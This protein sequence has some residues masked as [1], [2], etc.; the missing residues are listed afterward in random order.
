MRSPKQQP[1]R[2]SGFSLLEVMA[3]VA[4]LALMLALLTQ[5]SSST[6][7]A[8]TVTMKQIEATRSARAV[9]DTLSEDLAALVTSNDAASLF[10]KTD[11]ADSRLVFVTLR[12]GPQGSNARFIAVD[13]AL[14][15]GTVTRTVSPLA[16]NAVDFATAAFATNTLADT[17][18]LAEGIVRFEAVLNLDNGDTRTLADPGSWKAAEWNGTALPADFYAIHLSRDE[19][20]SV[21]PKVAGLTVAIAALDMGSY[22]L[23]NTDQIAAK[24]PPA[25]ANQTP[26]DTWKIAMTPGS[27]TGI[28][29]VAV[30][31]LRI[32]QRTYPL[33]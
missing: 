6:M 1:R 5:L 27:M 33:P 15:N 3:A 11:G 17:S 29:E 9:L 28:P 12:R 19:P 4:V 16:W 18:V 31:A 7:R 23:P 30:A 8:T 22:R 26:L 25:V 2:R 21:Q 20:D 24:L 32:L 13:Y 14:Q 10:I